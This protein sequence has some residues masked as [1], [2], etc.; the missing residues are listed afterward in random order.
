MPTISNLPF[1]FCHR[2]SQ[3]LDYTSLPCSSVHFCD[4]VV[5]H[6]NKVELARTTAGTLLLRKGWALLLLFCPF[7]CLIATAKAACRDPPLYGVFPQTK[8]SVM[9]AGCPTVQLNSGILYPET[10][11]DPAG[12][13]LSPTRLCPLQISAARPAC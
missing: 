1:I 4:G 8:Q 2:S 6:G 10:A 7:Y 3:E 13:G 11:S 5:A 12:K 9:P